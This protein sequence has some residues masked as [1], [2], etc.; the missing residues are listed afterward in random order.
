MKKILS[1]LLVALLVA[2]LFVPASAASEPVLSSQVLNSI[3]EEAKT[4][5]GV[6]FKYDMN[7]SN[8]KV[9]GIRAFAGADIAIDGATYKLV[10]MGAVVANTDEIGTDIDAMVLENV[11]GDRLINIDALRLMEW[12]DTTLSFAIRVTQIP[13]GQEK[14]RLYARPY[15]IYKDAD[16]ER[17]TVYGGITSASYYSVWCANNPVTLPEIGTDIDVTNQKGRIKV[18]DAFI[19]ERTVTLTFKNY[20]T[21]WITE[22]T[23]YVQYS[24]NDAA[25]KK[26]ATE[27]IY[28]GCIDTKKNK[29]KT[30]T[31]E[32]P[33]ET[34]KV[35]LT[36]SKIVYWT[37][38]S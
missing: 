35:K 3:T 32:V 23:D 27:T 9:S 7:V 36:G 13:A 6:A 14:T 5:L 25:G 22:E 29:T 38:W 30:F 8:L 15:Y 26:I 16:G 12:S 24:S 33:D 31:F 4:G 17:V 20:T 37:E 2:A 10:K 19:V 34:A 21:N 18:S 28:I 11:T 1:L